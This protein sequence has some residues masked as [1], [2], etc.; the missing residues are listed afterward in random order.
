MFGSGLPVGAVLWVTLRALE[1]GTPTAYGDCLLADGTGILVA[2]VLV[3]VGLFGLGARLRSEEPV[4]ITAPDN[5]L[6]A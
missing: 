2:C 6:P 1:V 3:A 5:P 4:D